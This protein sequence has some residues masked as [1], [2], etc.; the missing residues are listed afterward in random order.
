MRKFFISMSLCLAVARAASA[1]PNEPDGF[2]TLKFGASAAAAKA[3]FPAIT[4]KGA[5]AFLLMYELQGQSVFGLKPCALE[6]RF[7]D[8]QLYEVQ[9]ACEPRNK[10]AATL[11]KRFGEPTQEKADGTRWIGERGTVG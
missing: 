11:R 4:H 1:F 7:V 5:E 9:C 3:A 10:V 6:L 2:G 8:D